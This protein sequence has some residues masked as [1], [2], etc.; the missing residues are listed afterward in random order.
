MRTDV[1]TRPLHPRLLSPGKNGN[2][3]APPVTGSTP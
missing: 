2:Y 3:S 1:G